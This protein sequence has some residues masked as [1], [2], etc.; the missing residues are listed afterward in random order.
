MKVDA[1]ETL[2]GVVKDSV[3]YFVND[4]GELVVGDS[5]DEFVCGLCL[6]CNDVVGAEFFALRGS[7][8]VRHDGECWWFVGGDGERFPVACCIDGGILK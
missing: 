3:V 6:A 2:G 8:A 7:G 1:V 5:E 4:C